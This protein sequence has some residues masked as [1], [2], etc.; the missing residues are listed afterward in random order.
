MKETFRIFSNQ[1][2]YLHTYIQEAIAKNHLYDATSA[3]ISLIRALEIGFSDDLIVPFAEYSSDI[4]DILLNVKKRYQAGMLLPQ[5]AQTIA[6]STY[7]DKVISL[8][9]DY[10]ATMKDGLDDVKVLK[11][12]SSRELEILS[13]LVQGKTNQAIASRLFVAEVTVRKHL[14]AL[15]KKLD[16]RK[17]AEAVRRA[18][19]LGIV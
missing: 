4:M 17:R 8:V 7:L 2:G 9:L 3:E 16:V 19:E 13:L 10:F 15:Y 6:F 11:M 5:N 14:T 1:L 18:L 12:L